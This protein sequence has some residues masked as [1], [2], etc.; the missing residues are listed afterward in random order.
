MHANVCK[1]E[2]VFNEIKEKIERI[3]QIERYNATV[4]NQVIKHQRKWAP[5]TGI[6][7]SVPQ[8]E[9]AFSEREQDVEEYAQQ[10]IVNM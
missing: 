2:I 10:Y 1:K 8:A 9:T 7:P 6:A 5:Y 3:H 4:K